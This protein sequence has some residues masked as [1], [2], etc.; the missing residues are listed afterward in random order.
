[1]MRSAR[2]AL[3]ILAGG[4]VLLEVLR[5]LAAFVLPTVAS[6][7]GGGSPDMGMIRILCVGDSHTYGS[8]VGVGINNT[9]NAAESDSWEA[10]AWASPSSLRGRHSAA[11][12][13]PVTPRRRS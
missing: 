6:R 5:Q 12:W 13:M 3:V 2:N 11:L 4:L 9:W 1:M 10:G 7:A 8:G